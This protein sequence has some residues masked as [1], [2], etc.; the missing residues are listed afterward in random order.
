MWTFKK[1]MQHVHNNQ[2]SAVQKP[3]HYLTWDFVSAL[4]ITWWLT[5]WVTLRSFS[6][7]L[8]SDLAPDLHHVRLPR[9][10]RVRSHPL[11]QEHEGHAQDHRPL[12]SPR[13]HQ[14]PRRWRQ[15]VKPA[16][17]LILWNI[18]VSFLPAI[19][20]FQITYAQN[21]EFNGFVQGGPSG[22]GQPFVDIEIKVAL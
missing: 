22:W 6:F 9:A 18:F 19:R 20:G 16:G 15:L 4:I 7:C 10:P 17:H 13:H 21:S 11:P 2:K 14:D 5:A 8:D 1:V 12:R 3:K